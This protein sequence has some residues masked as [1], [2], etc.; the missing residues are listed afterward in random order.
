MQLTEIALTIPTLATRR[1]PVIGICC[2]TAL[3]ASGSFASTNS[4]VWTEFIPEGDKPTASLIVNP[5]DPLNLYVGAGNHGLFESR[6]GGESWFEVTD[7]LPLEEIS[8]NEP[9][10]LLLPYELVIHP[11]RPEVR[12]LFALVGVSD[13]GGGW[14]FKSVDGGVSWVLT[15]HDLP[16]FH[17]EQP[18]IGYA[19]NFEDGG[20]YMTRDGGDSWSRLEEIARWVENIVLDPLIPGKL[21]ATWD[22]RVYGSDD[23]GSSWRPVDGLPDSNFYSVAT[24]PL[25]SG[26]MY[27]LDEGGVFISVDGGASLTKS[28]QVDDPRSLIFHP[29][30]PDIILLYNFE[31]SNS[32]RSFRSGDG[33]SSWEALA[34]PLADSILPITWV[35]HPVDPEIIFARTPEGGFFK[36]GDGG[37]SWNQILVTSSFARQLIVHPH[38]PSTVFAHTDL[39]IFESND[40]GLSW[41][42]LESPAGVDEVSRLLILPTRP[43]ILLLHASTADLGSSWYRM[44]LPDDATAI[45]EESS[46]V[47][48]ATFQLLPN[49]PNPFNGDTMLNYTLPAAANVELAVYNI[50]GQKVA[51]LV[52]GRRQAGVYTHHWDGRDQR[53]FPLS[54][55]VY[56]LRLRSGKDTQVQNLLLLR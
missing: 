4:G 6:N 2:A 3:I 53:G 9:V 28:L 40:N 38:Q 15:N 5:E 39:E 48:P 42:A 35:F 19:L 11:S 29:L 21:F 8:G 32:F 17:P 56:V 33:G 7:R 49:Y 46:R 52:T 16:V 24:H 20:Q 23:G 44:R 10:S 14:V 51:T 26:V 12:Y 36:S 27:A 45:Q 50:T 54:T 55:G 18:D 43:P 1:S 41:N 34:D 25:R 47:H 30:N 13:T 37:V 22:S 31:K